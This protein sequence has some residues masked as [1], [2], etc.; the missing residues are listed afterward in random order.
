MTLESLTWGAELDEGPNR[1]DMMPFPGE[2][3][4][5]MIHRGHPHCGGTTYL[6]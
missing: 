1:S 2:N 6:T 5:L 3:T 4:V